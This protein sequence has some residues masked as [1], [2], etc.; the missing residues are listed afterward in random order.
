[1]TAAQGA[2]APGLYHL[3]PAAAWAAAVAS[4]EH[5]FP[6]T[7]GADGFIH[8]TAQ[9]ALLVGVAN[10]FYKGEPG[11]WVCLV[12]DAAK[13]GGELRFEAAAPVGETA[14]VEGEELFPHLYGAGICPA[15][16]VAELRVRRGE[17]GEFLS[18]DDIRRRGGFR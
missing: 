7:I 4:G 15:A 9:P 5:Y 8:L 16:V 17:G 12:I 3:A 10:H 6:A 11:D 14:A 1:M 18:I 13:L 2:T